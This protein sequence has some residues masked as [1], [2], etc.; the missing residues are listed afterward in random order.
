M[1]ETNTQKFKD[2]QKKIKSILVKALRKR[3]ITPRDLLLI[4]MI[5]AKAEKIAQLELL[6]ELFKNPYPIF[7]E[8]ID[9]EQYD[10]KAEFEHIVEKFVSKMIMENPALATEISRE[11]LR[12]DA[13]IKKLAARFPEFAEFIKSKNK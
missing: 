4:L 2:L 6:I 5:F 3:A 11:S 8:L 7:Q 13:N 1:P 12:K 10:L 9:E